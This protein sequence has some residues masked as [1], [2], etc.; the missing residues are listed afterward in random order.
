MDETATTGTRDAAGERSSAPP[1]AR[2]IAAQLSGRIVGQREAVAEVAIA[3]A[4]RLSGVHAGNILMIGSSGMGK[5]TLMRAVEHYFGERPALQSPAAVA[6]PAPGERPIVLRLHANVLGREAERGRPGQ[7]VLLGLL[8][9]ARTVLGPEA[10]LEQLCERISGGVVFVDE[11]DKIRSQVEG[12]P[13]VAGIRAQESLL[14]LMENES[15]PV[16]LPE[17]LGSGRVDIDS[18]QLLFVAGGAFEGLYDA[19]YDRV[20]V[21]ADRGALQPVTVVEGTSVREELPFRLRDWLRPEDLFAYGMSPQFLSR[22]ESVVLLDDLRP[23]D[24]VQILLEAPDSPYL[25]ARDYFAAYGVDLAL[26]PSAAQRIAE[27]AARRKRIGARAL[28][29][30]FRQVVRPFEIDPPAAAE[31]GVLSIDLP[32]VERAMAR[33][34]DTI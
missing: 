15:V 1:T 2:Q 24:L 17:W 10:T 31:G 22:Y 12:E 26:S 7:V 23:G 6:A 20:T 11:V 32:E 14:T 5:T 8:E 9:Q 18:R 33:P 4:K 28:R 30:I 21:G 19:V 16:D 25:L 13:N 34:G 3:L 29:E 27:A